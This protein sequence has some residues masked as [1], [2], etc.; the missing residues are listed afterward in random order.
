MLVRRVAEIASRLGLVVT[1]KV[2]AQ[3][4]PVVGALGGA[5]VNTAFM[6][7]YQD[8]AHAH[9]TVRRLER[10]YGKLAVRSAYEQIRI[11]ELGEA[12]AISET[13]SGSQAQ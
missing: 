13:S 9:F 10:T 12:P 4:L 11:S 1:Q 6:D 8:V 5:V 3:A 2:A 7:H